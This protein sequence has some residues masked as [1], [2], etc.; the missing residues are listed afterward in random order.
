[1]KKVA[2]IEDR[3]DKAQQLIQFLKEDFESFEV[4]HFSSYISG[5][6]EIILNPT[7]DLLLLDMSMPNYDISSA[8]PGGDFIPLAGKHILNELALEDSNI[9]VIVVTQY[10]GFD[11]VSISELHKQF[12][13]EFNPNYKGIVYYSADKTSWKIN[14]KSLINEVL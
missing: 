10:G 5:L 7:Y 1:M 14:L 4:R 9:S 6:R 3:E 2:I 11:G 13:L 8:D 12:V